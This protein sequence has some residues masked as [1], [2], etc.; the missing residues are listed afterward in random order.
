MGV[1][2]ILVELTGRLKMTSKQ[3]VRADFEIFSPYFSPNWQL[4]IEITVSITCQILPD[5]FQ[6]I[7][8]VMG[9]FNIFVDPAGELAM[10]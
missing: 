2:N 4:N 9:V 10:M 3:D 5:V 8:N 7:C 1:F 6:S